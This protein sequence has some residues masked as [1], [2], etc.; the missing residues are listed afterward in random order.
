MAYSGAQYG[1]PVRYVM[2]ARHTPHRGAMDVLFAIVDSVVW[3]CT[4]P[5]DPRSPGSTATLRSWPDQI[6]AALVE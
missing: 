3:L 4:L 2:L 5:D 1:E 6:H